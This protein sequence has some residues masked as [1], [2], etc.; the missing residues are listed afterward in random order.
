MNSFLAVVY[1]ILIFLF[2]FC[3]VSYV[4]KRKEKIV[5]GELRCKELSEYLDKIGAPREVWLSE[6]ASGIV[7]HVAYDQSTNQLVGLVLPL[8]KNGMPVPFSFTPNSVDQINDHMKHNE[9][10]TLVYLI[11]AQPMKE[12]TAPFVLQVYGTNNKFKTNDVLQRWQHLND[13]LTRLIIIFICIFM[14][15][16]FQ[17]IFLFKF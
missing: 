7:S 16:I 2:V 4:Q 11:L 12:N 3:K 14:F 13:Q 17:Y 6:D 9:R 15:P 1:N 5:E 10:S 8:D